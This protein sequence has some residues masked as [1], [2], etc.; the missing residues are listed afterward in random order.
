[1]I[2]SQD[3]GQGGY[4]HIKMTKE[5]CNSHMF[6]RQDLARGGGG[7]FP[8]KTDR[9]VMYQPH[10]FTSRSGPQRGGGGIPI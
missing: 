1:M 6:L 9:G 7:V 5:Q 4:S 3:L 8:Y 2:P 10:V